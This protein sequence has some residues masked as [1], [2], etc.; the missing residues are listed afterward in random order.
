[1][2]PFLFSL[3]LKRKLFIVA[4]TDKYSL[5]GEEEE[6]VVTLD[7]LQEALENVLG[8]EAEEARKAAL[9][10]LNYFGYSTVIIDNAIDQEDRKLFYQLH[11][12]GL[13]NT[14]WETVIL[15]TGRAWRTFYW[16]LDELSIERALR[17]REDRK[18]EMIYESLPDEIWARA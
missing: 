4:K 7:K 1:M 11:D 8:L 14:F 16:E 17:R 15:P 6:M 3:Q 2:P 12:A 18:E 9:T 10:V 13:L 5:R